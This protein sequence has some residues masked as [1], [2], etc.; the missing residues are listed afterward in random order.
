MRF[1]RKRRSPRAAA[2]AILAL[3]VIAPSV[4]AAVAQTR[5]AS[6]P[7]KGVPMPH[8]VTSRMLPLRAAR[9]ELVEFNIAPP[10][11]YTGKAPSGKPFLDVTDEEGRRGHR[12]SR[13][14]VLWE[15][16][17]FSDRRALMFI[18]KGFDARRPGLIVVFLHGHRATIDRDVRDRQRVADQIALSNVNAVLVAPQFAVDASDS[19]AGRFWESYGFASFLGEAGAH[20]ARLHGDWRTRK[21]FATLPVVVVA[22]SG[23]YVPAAWALHK[24][25]TSNRV[26]GVLML[27]ALYG[28]AYKYADWIE[29]HPNAFFVSSYTS[30][31]ARGNEA[32]RTLLAER[33]IAASGSLPARL[34]G[35]VVFLP[36]GSGV[37]HESFVTQAWAETPIKDVL[38]RIAGYARTQPKRTESSSRDPLGDL[39]RASP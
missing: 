15:D 17:S 5:S 20:L 12:T 6:A 3:A 32:L 22:Y 31:S 2:V 24:G 7:P 30:S 35:G 16:V 4:D 18:P 38:E 11:P 8:E 36:T 27:D 21:T 34:N 39:I 29:R 26:I 19:S 9:S 37:S 25:G 23:G 33:E 14:G 10:F 28:E 1:G 13:G